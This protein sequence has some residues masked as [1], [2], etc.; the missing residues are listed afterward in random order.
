MQPLVV[1]SLLLFPSLSAYATTVTQGTMGHMM[2]L[3]HGKCELT[4]RMSIV[5]WVTVVAY[6]GRGCKWTSSSVVVD[7]ACACGGGA[8]WVAHILH[9]YILYNRNKNSLFLFLTPTFTF[10]LNISININIKIKI[11]INPKLYSAEAEA[12]ASEGNSH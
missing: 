2:S 4:D 10:C 7:G 8:V 9:L 6:A 5:P 3:N 12:L 11:N 1:F